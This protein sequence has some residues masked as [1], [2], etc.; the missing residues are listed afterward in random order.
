M[1][2]V[3]AEVEGIGRCKLGGVW[4]FVAEGVVVGLDELHLYIIL[5]VLFA[6]DRPATVAD[7]SE[8]VIEVTATEADPI[9]TGINLRTMLSVGFLH[10]EKINI[11]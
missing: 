7:L 11:I 8:G 9:S 3:L 10:G 2:V 4:F 1:G 6:C 5:M